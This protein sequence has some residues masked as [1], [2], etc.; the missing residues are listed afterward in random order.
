MLILLQFMRILASMI[1]IATT[2]FLILLD[3]EAL[4]RFL[5]VRII[6]WTHI[7]GI[8]LW[9]LRRHLCWSRSFIDYIR[10]RMFDIRKAFFRW[11]IF[12]FNWN[13]LLIR[14]TINISKTPIFSFLFFFL[15]IFIWPAL[16]ACTFLNCPVRTVILVTTFADPIL[17]HLIFRIQMS[18]MIWIT[19]IVVNLITFSFGYQLGRSNTI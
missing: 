8:A 6:N 5:R 2:I 14:Y 18:I 13:S 11:N 3:L 19:I 17:L 9:I 10:P 4:Q 12:K 7:I 15:V 16:H 1:A